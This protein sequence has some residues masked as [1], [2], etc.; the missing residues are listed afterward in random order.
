[1]ICIFFSELQRSVVVEVEE[2]PFG[3]TM[4]MICRCIIK[5]TERIGAFFME[6]LI[7]TNQEEVGQCIAAVGMGLSVWIILWKTFGGGGVS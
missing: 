3:P 5:A 7:P 6:Y 2:P 1:V 4:M